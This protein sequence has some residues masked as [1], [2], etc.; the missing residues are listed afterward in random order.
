MRL[1]QRREQNIPSIGMNIRGG[2]NRYLCSENLAKLA[3]L[4]I[5]NLQLVP[6]PHMEN[7]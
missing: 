3:L 1:K 4:G 5:K 7:L 6:L 2:L